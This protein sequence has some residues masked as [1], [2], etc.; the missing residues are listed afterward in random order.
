MTD[1]PMTP[2]QT[3]SDTMSDN[4]LYNTLNNNSLNTLSSDESSQETSASAFT[5]SIEEDDS[6][7]DVDPQVSCEDTNEKIRLSFLPAKPNP[8]PANQQAHL[9]EL[10]RSAMSD[11]RRIEDTIYRAQNYDPNKRRR[12][13]RL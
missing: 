7:D 8:S 5:F 1:P 10:H 2:R 11:R 12:G 3:T 6:D 9:Q 13:P 4:K